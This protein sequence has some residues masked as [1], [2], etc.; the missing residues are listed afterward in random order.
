MG[1]AGLILCMKICK[2]ARKLLRTS[3]SNPH[4]GLQRRTLRPLRTAYKVCQTCVVVFRYWRCEWSGACCA[5]T[6]RWKHALSGIDATV[7]TDDKAMNNHGAATPARQSGDHGAAIPSCEF[8]N[9]GAAIPSGVIEV[10]VTPLRLQG[11]CYTWCS[12]A[13]LM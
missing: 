1:V 7:P 4:V 9:H 13:Q 11:C 6:C 8:C 3:Y 5:F 2:G 12:L 10:A